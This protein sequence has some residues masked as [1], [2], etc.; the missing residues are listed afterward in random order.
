MQLVRSTLQE[1]QVV[2]SV[3]LR[4]KKKPVRQEEQVELEE[5]LEQLEMAL[6]QHSGTVKLQ[7]LQ[8]PVWRK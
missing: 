5:H 4:G 6:W 7:A 3:E 8:T 2:L 1:R